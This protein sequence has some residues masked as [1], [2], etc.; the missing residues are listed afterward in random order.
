M[1]T[2]ASS[3]ACAMRPDASPPASS[4]ERRRSRSP[5]SSC[6]EASAAINRALLTGKMVSIEEAQQWGFVHEVVPVATLPARVIGFGLG[7]LPPVFVAALAALATRTEVHLFQFNPC[8]EYW[9]DIVSERTRARWQLLTPARAA[10]AET[11]N[12]LLYAGRLDALMNFAGGLSAL[13]DKTTSGIGP[14]W[15]QQWDLRSQF[16][17]YIWGLQ[18]AGIDRLVVGHTPVGDVPGLAC[19]ASYLSPRTCPKRHA[20]CATARSA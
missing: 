7:A 16:T 1:Y 8:S 4:A 11:G 20:R 3:T 14:K 9:Y 2:L 18:R 17:A 12:P 10:H 6:P 15:S 19:A 13:D 5:S